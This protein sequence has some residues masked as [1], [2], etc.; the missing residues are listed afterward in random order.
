MV[1]DNMDISHRVVISYLGP[2][3]I[4]EDMMVT[5]GENPRSYSIVRKWAVEFKC[6]RGSLKTKPVGEPHRRPLPGC[7]TSSR[8]TDGKWSI[9]LPLS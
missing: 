8:Q 9:T 4:H 6:D 5:L 2:K 1:S 3:E 7:M